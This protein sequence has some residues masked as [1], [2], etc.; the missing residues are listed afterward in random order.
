MGQGFGK[1]T[2]SKKKAIGRA[3]PGVAVD[4]EQVQEDWLGYFGELE[5]PRGLQGVEHP[6]LSIVMIAILA[7][8]GGA[9]GWEDIETYGE[10]HEGWLVSFLALPEGIPSADTY[11]RLFEQG[12][13]KKQQAGSYCEKQ[14]SFLNREALLT[15]AS[16][17]RMRFSARPVLL[18][19]QCTLCSD[20][21]CACPV[22]KAC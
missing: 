14:A 19:E 2:S 17:E 18:R 1:S 16:Y 3:A 9:K 8:I 13:R 15:V 4:A 7:T 20:F 21:A 5:D 10:A 11:R 22:I 6:F 12:K